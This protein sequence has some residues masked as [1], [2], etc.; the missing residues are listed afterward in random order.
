MHP[1]R[2]VKVFGDLACAQET[3]RS[4]RTTLRAFY[5]WAVDA[6]ETTTN[7]ALALPV[8]KATRPNPRPVPDR[9][10]AQSLA[11]ATP[12]EALMIR[13]AAEAG[14]RRTE[15]ATG[16]SDNLIEDLEGWTLRVLGKGNKVRD[17]PLPDDLADE[18]L[19]LPAGWFFPGGDNGHLSPRW[20]GTLL[21]RLMPGVWTMHKLR[22]R[23][24]T[25]WYEV[26]RDVFV[27]QQLLGHA[28][29]ATTQAYVAVRDDRL[30]RTVTSAA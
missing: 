18:L 3:R 7:T 27:V 14:L 17:V 28:S 25:R 9:V 10:Y 20:V 11:A 4:R 24:A 26:D 8:V 6:G 1:K 22:H 30:R 15:V 2:L 29:P 21:S 5:R 23:A 16:H 13:L 12:R 19:A